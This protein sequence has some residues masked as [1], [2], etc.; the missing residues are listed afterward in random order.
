MTQL[1]LV[2]E[3]NAATR[4]QRRE[5]TG[6]LGAEPSAERA[7]KGPLVRLV[8]IDYPSLHLLLLLCRL[9]SLVRINY[10]V[11]QQ[12][13]GRSVQKIWPFYGSFFCSE[14]C[15]SLSRDLERSLAGIRPR[16]VIGRNRGRGLKL[17]QR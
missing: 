4:T 7:P 8:S 15:P 6:E 16:F 2:Q 14:N 3:D 1:R 12:T 10:W 17:D 13:V 9:G 11:R 5:K